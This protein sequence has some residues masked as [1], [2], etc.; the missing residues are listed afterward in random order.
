MTIVHF[1]ILF[2]ILAAYLTYKGI[3]RIREKDVILN[4]KIKMQWWGIGLS[5]F[6]TDLSLSYIINTS[7][8][9][10]SKGLAVGSYGWTSVLVIIVVALFILPKYMQ[11]GIKTLPEYLELRFSPYLRLF[12]AIVHILFVVLIAL[13]FVYHSFGV[14]IVNTFGLNPALQVPIIA[15]VGIL[16]GLFLFAGG[17]KMAI[18]FDI[19]IAAIIILAGMVVFSFALY[20]VGGFQNLTEHAQGKMNV[21]LPADDDYLPWTQVFFGGVWLLHLNYWAFFQPMTQ[22]LVSAESLSEAQKGLMLTATLKLVAPFIFLIP[23]IICFELYASQVTQPDDVFPVLLRNILPEALSPIIVLAFGITV[24]SSSYAYLHAVGTMF[25]NDIFTRFIHPKTSESLKEKI[26]LLTILVAIT[27]A[28]ILAPYITQSLN[29]SLL[30]KVLRYAFLPG[31]IIVFL[32]GLF[33]T[34]SYRGHAWLAILLSIVLYFGARY[35][36][37]NWIPLQVLGINTV[38]IAIVSFFVILIFPSKKV[39]AVLGY[40]EIPFERNLLVMIWGI[41]IIT[42]VCSIYVIFS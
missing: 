19:I 12:F 26:Y 21:L 10:F 7:G 29:E 38:A 35:F 28:V 31:I 39:E 41:F 36:F 17:L 8:I 40:R 24:I 5:V 1:T 6:A 27:I 11:L 32:I 18:K 23:S 20:A 42:L 13:S 4:E 15:F 33:S 14:L 37:P 34:K 9:G 22:K 2:S 25:T 16:S 3:V 30:A